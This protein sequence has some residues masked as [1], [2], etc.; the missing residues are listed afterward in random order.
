MQGPRGGPGPSDSFLLPLTQACRL[1]EELKALKNASVSLRPMTFL[2]FTK[3]QLISTVHDG[4]LNSLTRLLKFS[5]TQKAVIKGRENSASHST[6]FT[7][8]RSVPIK[9][10]STEI[11]HQQDMALSVKAYI[12]PDTSQQEIR[13][14][15]IDE[16]AS[17]SY[18]YLVK[19]IEQV[20]PVVRGKIFKLFWKGNIN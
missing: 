7:D 10:K 3:H 5:R 15:A 12:H 6:S 9:L 17:A 13:R 11:Y 8:E 14:F 18:T 20:F 4:A 19:K 16:G 1:P 2:L